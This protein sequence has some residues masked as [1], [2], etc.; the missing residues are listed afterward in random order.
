MENKTKEQ[1]QYTGHRLHIGRG[2]QT[3]FGLFPQHLPPVWESIH[4]SRQDKDQSNKQDAIK[5]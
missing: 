4:A 3:Q 2:S 5:T 1:I